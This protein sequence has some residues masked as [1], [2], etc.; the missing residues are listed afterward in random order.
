[1]NISIKELKMNELEQVIGG[2][3]C[4]SGAFKKAGKWLSETVGTALDKTAT[5]ARNVTTALSNLILNWIG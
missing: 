4:L 5:A 1:M 2:G 3:A